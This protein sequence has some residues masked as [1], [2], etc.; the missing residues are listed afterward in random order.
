MG[1]KYAIK[2]P[3]RVIITIMKK[4][5]LF[6][7]DE[8]PN[9]LRHFSM[10]N[11][12]QARS[13]FRLGVR[14][15]LLLP[16]VFIIL[17][18]IIVVLPLTSMLIA[19][20]LEADADVR[21]EQVAFGVG[22]LIEQAEDEI[23]LT[24][25]LIANLPE[26]ENIETDTS[27]AE[28]VLLPQR[29]ELNLQELSYYSASFERGGNAVFS[30]GSLAQISDENA[31]QVREN[32]ILEALETG[33]TVSGVAISEQSSLIIAVAP[34]FSDDESINGAILAVNFIDDDFLAT[35]GRILTVEVAIVQ[36]NNAVAGTIDPSSNF[37]RL[38]T[39]G[40]V[41]S[42]NAI[43]TT[44]VRYDDGI[45]RRLMAHPLIVDNQVQATVL[46]ARSLEDLNEVQRNIQNAILLF[47]ALFA[48]VMLAFTVEI[49]VNIATPIKRL[50]EA[51]ASV[52]GGQLQEQVEVKGKIIE[53][54]ITD[55][56][57][58]FNS[59]TQRLDE[60]YS[61]L[62][63]QVADRTLELRNALNELEIKRDEALDA[64][65][66]KSIF[67]ANMSHELRTPLNAIIG[68]SE[69]L[70][71][72]AEDFGYEDIIP[73]LRKIQ[74]A[75]THLLALINDILDISKIEAGKVELYL[76]EID[77][78][79]L[80]DEIV[81]TIQPVINQKQNELI[82]DADEALG[83]VV[84]DV[85]KLRQIIFNLL[86]NAAKFTEEGTIRLEAKRE[87][88][89]S[90]DWVNIKVIDT[91]IGMTQEQTNRIFSEFMQADSS[92][93]R[94]YG[95]TGLGLPISRHFAQVMGGDITVNSEVN[96]G[97][98]FDVRLPAIVQLEEA[99]TPSLDDTLPVD[100]P[101]RKPNKSED[102]PTVLIIDDD[103]TIQELLRRQLEREGF[104]VVAAYTGESG[105]AQARNLK[106]NVIALDVLMPGMDGWTVLN[107]IQD[108]ETIA[109]IPVIILSMLDDKPIG[110]ALGAADYLRKP[111]ERAKLIEILNRHML[112]TQQE[113]HILI[114]E[115][116]L[117]T[118]DLF[119]RT[120]ERE[121]WQT[122]IAQN[123]V[124]GLARL[125]KQKP[126]LILLDL[127][128]PEMDGFTFINEMRANDD[129]QDIPIIVITAKSLTQEDKNTLNESTQRVV[130]KAD[131][132]PQTLVAEIQRV[133]EK[134]QSQE[135]KL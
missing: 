4:S 101:S 33:E 31:I 25:S 39:S 36:N 87:Q 11:E 24:A 88:H 50:A 113:S 115:D 44:N 7:N 64:N 56:S 3:N 48:I 57:H 83:R 80:I 27:T 6:T 112:I 131:Y 118:R 98:E 51:T 68:Y 121:G 107:K 91:G 65:R 71:E 60:L 28:S 117:D 120:A 72:E 84:A 26:V 97:S 85:T 93:T 61:N 86:S 122:H 128:M 49:F 54:E 81:V 42:S 99:D 8:I 15:K 29:L 10:E 108:D 134:H 55:I 47:V 52:S 104:N 63:Q 62:E 78:K 75:G 2:N 32:L 100:M 30:S 40:F 124:E 58:T 41:N 35:I 129:W 132:T 105:L 133:L 102:K 70:E 76:E 59:M 79:T 13:K 95:G 77:L 114:I 38:L 116:D 130:Q 74:N 125:Q 53:D 126:D 19:R 106:P 22:Q 111:V 37:Q 89:L 34:V 92:T 73:D 110:L 109:H 135:G 21:L 66:T 23:R 9:K 46:I 16:F 18:V 5:N 12:N 17:L 20:Q 82:V 67:L 90:G 119:V 94:K 43:A 45:T 127:M 96:A 103:A 1:T 69:M 123:G 14:W